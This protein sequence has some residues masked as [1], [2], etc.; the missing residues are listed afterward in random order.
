MIAIINYGL[1]NIGSIRNMFKKIGVQAEIIES[2]DALVNADKIILPGVGTFD[3][4]MKLLKNNNWLE[5]L[6]QK[7]LIDKVPVLGICLGMQLMTKSS[8]EGN[9]PGL[10]WVDGVVKKFQFD[11]TNIKIPHMGWNDVFP[12]MESPLFDSLS[13]DARF[14]HVHSYYVS[15]ND[16]NG[17][18]AET[19]YEGKFT[20]SFNFGNIYGVQFHPEKS[21]KY[22]KALLLNFS[23]L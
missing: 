22:G 5:A 7:V 6:N 14:Y 18:I 21:H 4:G 10:G 15:I 19:N 3:D 11:N 12:K 2:P 17:I 16:S 9:E 13:V 23:K 8:E 20:S 1:G